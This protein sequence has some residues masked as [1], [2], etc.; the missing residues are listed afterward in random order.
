MG[1]GIPQGADKSVLLALAQERQRKMALT[2]VLSDMLK[3]TG[4][5][6]PSQLQASPNAYDTPGMRNTPTNDAAPY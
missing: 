5:S 6:M 3:S 1:G 2:K 4:G